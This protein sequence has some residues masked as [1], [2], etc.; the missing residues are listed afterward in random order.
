[1]NYN[2]DF[3]DKTPIDFWNSNL[4]TAI[5]AFIGVLFSVGLTFI[6]N[7]KLAS[8]NEKVQKELLEKQIDAEKIASEKHQTFEDWLAQ[9]Q[10]NFEERMAQKQI[11]ANLKAS[12]R[13]DWIQ[14]V[15]LVETEF[16]NN[17]NV[18]SMYA[19]S[20]FSTAKSFSY[21]PYNDEKTSYYFDLI[22]KYIEQST[23]H[24]SEARK[25][26][27]LLKLYFGTGS[28]DGEIISLSKEILDNIEKIYKLNNE[29]VRGIESEE[30]G[31]L[32]NQVNEVESLCVM[33]NEK[34]DVFVLKARDYNKTEWD[35]AKKGE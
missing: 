16:I 13:I 31:S 8:R 23:S 17:A 10:R 1:M 18:F 19:T 14:K 6:I 2:I 29:I 5:L 28:E 25:N 35:R 11:D 15:R 30:I 34:I 33:Q 22:N 12:A 32:D 20:V 7:K 27:V 26:A 3:V 4:M 9:N 21:D 24:F